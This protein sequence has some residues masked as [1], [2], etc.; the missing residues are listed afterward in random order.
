MFLSESARNL[1]VF[2]IQVLSILL[3]LSLAFCCFTMM[4]LNVDI[5]FIYIVWY[6]FCLSVK[7]CL[8]FRNVQF[9]K[10]NSYPLCKYVISSSLSILSILFVLRLI[11]CMMFVLTQPIIFLNSD[12]YITIPCF[13][14]C[15]KNQI[16]SLCHVSDSLIF[17]LLLLFLRAVLVLQQ[18]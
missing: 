13:I 5:D 12:S 6:T 2:N 14:L 8:Y 16:V 1:V 10:M 15:A 9:Q 3:F 18:N 4:C 17:F 11:V 7:S